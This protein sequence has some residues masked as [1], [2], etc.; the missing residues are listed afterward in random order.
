MIFCCILFD[1]DVD[2]EV[3]ECSENLSEHSDNIP[4]KKKKKRIIYEGD[5][6]DGEEGGSGGEVGK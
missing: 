2:V 4:M 3:Q 1:F 6:E 5:G